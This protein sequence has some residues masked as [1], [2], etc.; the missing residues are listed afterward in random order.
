MI[1]VRDVR[2]AYDGILAL[3]G[4]SLNV[5]SGEFVGLIG[6]NGCGKS[7]LVRVAS[8]IIKPD[9]GSVELDDKPLSEMSRNEIARTV[10]VVPQE[11][12]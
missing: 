9:E 1:R 8:G 4:L 6:P 3:E 5:A 10:A 2:V 11:S 7:T 12:H